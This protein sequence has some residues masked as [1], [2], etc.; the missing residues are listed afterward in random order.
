MKQIDFKSAFAS[1]AVVVVIVAGLLVSQSVVVVDE[2][3]QAIIT[4][5][6]EFRRA[7]KEAGLHFKVPFVQKVNYLERRTLSSDAASQEYLTLDKKRAVVDHVTRWR[8]TDPLRFFVSVRTEMGAQARLDDIVFSE[9]RRQLAVH[10]L[11]DVIAEKR[12]QIMDDVAE[13]ARLQAKNFGIH[14]VDVRIK[15]ADLP[16]AVQESVFKRMEAERKRESSRYR[17]E[18]EE[19][20]ALIRAESNRQRE[21][22]LADAREQAQRTRGEGDAQAIAIYA[23]A[24]QQDPEFYTFTRRL[25]AYRKLLGAEDLLVLDSNAEFF[26]YLLSHTDTAGSKGELER[27]ASGGGTA[28][29]QA[30]REPAAQ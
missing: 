4:Q 28:A 23:E 5:F 25:E 26:R 16:P 19:R 18:G 13:S 17:A 2:T 14:I 10:N 24:L 6:G 22:I 20:G 9:L 15:R 29:A 21:I 27:K 12:E 8:I 1:V 3:N 11:E 7:I 30:A